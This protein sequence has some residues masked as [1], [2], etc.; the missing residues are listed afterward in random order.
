MKNLLIIPIILSLHLIDPCNAHAQTGW[1]WGKGCTAYGSVEIDAWAAAADKDGN[2]YAGGVI[3]SADS[4]RFGPFTVYDPGDT[5][6][7]FITKADSLGTYQWVLHNQ[8]GV[9]LPQCMATDTS[10]NLYILALYGSPTFKIGTVTLTQSGVNNMY[11]L[12]KVSP[13]G[14]VLWA[15]NIAPEEFT[16]FNAFLSNLG[17]AGN[18][19]IDGAGNVYVSGTFYSAS[20]TIGTVTLYNGRTAGGAYNVFVAKYDPSG[21]LVWAKG[22]ADK[23]NIVLRSMAVS[24]HGAVY[25]AG[26][27][28]DTLTTGGVMLTD[29]LATDSLA[30][31][32]KMDSTGHTSWASK[33]GQ[34]LLKYTA[35]GTDNNDRVYVAGYFNGS[36]TYGS[37]TL[38][39]PAGYGYNILVACLDSSSAVRWV[40]AAYDTAAHYR[41]VPSVVNVDNC[42]KLCVSGTFEY[43]P[44]VP[45]ASHFLVFGTDTLRMPAGDFDPLFLAVYDTSGSYYMS[46][47]LAGGGEDWNGAAVD[48]RG[49]VYICS[50]NADT[51]IVVSDTL[52]VIAVGAET[53][54]FAKYHYGTGMCSLTTEDTHTTPTPQ[55][56]ISLYPN[57]AFESCTIKSDQDFG[58][59]ATAELYDV[60][61]R[62]VATYPL[63]G[64]TATISFTGISPGM[65]F[66]RIHPGDGSNV[67][68][69]KLVVE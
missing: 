20:I 34:Y 63:Y 2:V 10:G 5:S 16:S 46:S 50:D 23:K 62:R 4:T 49:N 21:S 13:S 69:K 7:L 65:Y 43:G 30:F 31:V 12:I 47:A 41:N 56:G 61:G 66:C 25:V 37:S 22:M 14:S 28:E 24:E 15:E 32:V 40:R 8:V 54:Y 59:G 64:N 18:I 51:M 1:K 26:E 53:F 27:F 6:K 29:S 45:P 11:A 3:F 38:T 52:K 68:V 33:N 35:I 58:S 39:P 55:E 60:Q 36:I 17:Y 48:N 44:S 19:G 42:G 57:P 9:A 67:T